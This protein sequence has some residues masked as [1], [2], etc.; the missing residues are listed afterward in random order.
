MSL[1]S[2]RERVCKECSWLCAKSY[3]ATGSELVFWYQIWWFWQVFGT[4]VLFLVP[5]KIH[6]M[7]YVAKFVLAYKFL[8]FAWLIWMVGFLF[9]HCSEL[10]YEIKSIQVYEQLYRILR[11]EFR[12]NW[13]KIG[14][15]WPWHV[16]GAIVNFFDL[17]H[18]TRI[19]QFILYQDIST[20][21]IFNYY[22][23]QQ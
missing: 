4:M 17:I 1:N 21:V 14:L 15:G 6:V 2:N 19:V 10:R 18:Y 8:M 23:F 20:R 12:K 7:F 16:R 5:L 13:L 11:T 3:Y 22:S 9:F